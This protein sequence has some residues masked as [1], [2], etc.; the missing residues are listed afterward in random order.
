[1]NT[2]NDLQQITKDSIAILADKARE[3]IIQNKYLL[4]K[5]N[6]FKN[7]IITVK[8][9][10]NNFWLNSNQQKINNIIASKYK[11][12]LSLFNSNLKEEINKGQQKLKLLHKNS[13]SELSIE[14]RT[15]SQLSIDNFILNNTLSK[16]NSTTQSLN[17]SIETSKKHEIFREPKRESIIDIKQSKT[18]FPVYNL[19]LQQKML[20]YCRAYSKYR[21]KNAK[22]L[23]KINIQKQNINALIDFIKT[24]TSKLAEKS[25][26]NKPQTKNSKIPNNSNINNKIIK[27]KG[28]SKGKKLKRTK[29]KSKFTNNILEQ[30]LQEPNIVKSNDHRQ[31]SFNKKNSLN[32]SVNNIFNSDIKTKKEKPTER[33]KIN[34][35]KIDE[36]LDID[37]IEAEDENII[38][39]ELNSDDD[40]FFEKKVKPKKTINKEYITDLRKDVPIINLSQIEFNKI[41]VIN[42]ADAYS[43]QKRKLEQN[44]ITWQIKNFKKQIKNLEK[45]ISINKNKLKVIHNFIEDVKYNYKLLRPIK[46]QSSAAGN[47]VTYIREKLLDVVGE[48]ISKAEKKEGLGTGK[49]T[50]KTAVEEGA[51]DYEDEIVGSD[52]SDEDEYIENYKDKDKDNEI[53]EN[54]G[55]I[56]GNHNDNDI[57]K[58]N[59]NNLNINNKDKTSNLNQNRKTKDDKVK[60]NNKD[61]KANLLT[62]F[63]HEEGKVNSI[64]HDYFDD[65]KFNGALSN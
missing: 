45:Q 21:Y 41:K 53:N 29:T 31:N 60:K 19:E 33:K 55:G 35:L 26:E 10:I 32:I 23:I 17:E 64:G 22:K 44:N 56:I 13:L 20:S 52:Y 5:I 59:V 14:D 1:M 24:Y 9:L 2:I 8:N 39:N 54:K 40:V 37:N 18:V 49:K 58:E 42:E 6:I 50:E 11:E 15:L 48:T 65:F 62:K 63:N 47:P 4:E 46:V 57:D 16:L 51:L 7:E 27:Q 38:D 36:L 3:N 28:K 25:Q 30:K 43:F 34:I 12:Q 61:I